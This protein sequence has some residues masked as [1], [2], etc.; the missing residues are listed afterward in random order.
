MT[1]IRILNFR[2]SCINICCRREFATDFQNLLGV[3][4][5]H[6]GDSEMFGDW[7]G[8]WAGAPH[9]GGGGQDA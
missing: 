7:R 4:D 9:G 3:I 5:G 6:W 1:Q 2:N 8:S